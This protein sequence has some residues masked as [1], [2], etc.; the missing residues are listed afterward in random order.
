[1]LDP[2]NID[3]TNDPLAARYVKSESVAVRFARQAGEL[4]SLEGPNRYESGD[5][6][7]AGS[8]G[9]RWSVAR[10]RFDA[11]YE[12]VPPTLTGQ[13]GRY[14]ARPLPVMARQIAEPF[15]AARSSGGD[16]LRGN[17]GDWLLQYGPGDFGVAAHQRFTQIY[18]KID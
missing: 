13:D 11:K 17:A 8:T 10:H 4:I 14:A 16:V 18:R 15:T 1:M 5:A 7:I 6:L 9:S 2:G 3:L 12:A